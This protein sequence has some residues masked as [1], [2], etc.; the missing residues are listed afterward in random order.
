MPDWDQLLMDAIS[1][2]QLELRLILAKILWT[3]DF[4]LTDDSLDWVA[5]NKA[6]GFWEKP[7]LLA[8]FCRRTDARKHT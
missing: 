6:Y 5:A 2:A 1:L 8:Q 3:F 4:K 7:D